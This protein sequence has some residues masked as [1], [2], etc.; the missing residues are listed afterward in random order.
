M[1]FGSKRGALT[2]NEGQLEIIGQ[3]RRKK[4]QS[5]WILS[6]AQLRGMDQLRSKEGLWN[7]VI[8]DDKLEDI[9]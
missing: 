9:G 7:L 2:P 4:G 5:D 1:G 6:G 3:L 8:K